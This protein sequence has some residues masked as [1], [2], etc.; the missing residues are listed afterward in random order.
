MTNNNHHT[1]LSCAYAETL[2]AI[3]YNEATETEKRQFD[4]HLGNCDFCRDE[5]FSLGMVRSAVAEWRKA[6]FDCLENPSI[7]LPSIETTFAP[8]KMRFSWVERLRELLRTKSGY[9]QGATAFAALVIGV[10]LLAIFGYDFVNRFENNQV[11]NNQIAK[12]PKIERTPLVSTSPTPPPNSV[13]NPLIDPQQVVKNSAN[14]GNGKIKRDNGSSKPAVTLIKSAPPRSP[15]RPGKNSNQPNS[16]SPKSDDVAL[17]QIDD[18]EDNSL[19][20][21]DLLDDLTPSI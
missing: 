14:G 4:T 13:T 17:D 8:H 19:R 2:V 1:D 6:D 11:A 7:I 20:L 3:L 15:S 16:I 5:L 18:L 12:A 10:G 21:S 9:L